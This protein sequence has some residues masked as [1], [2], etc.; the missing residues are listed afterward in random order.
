MGPNGGTQSASTTHLQPADSVGSGNLTTQSQPS[1]SLVSGRTTIPPKKAKTEDPR[2]AEAYRILKETYETKIRDKSQAFGN[3]VASKHRD[4]SKRTKAFVEHYINNILFDADLGK[5]DCEPSSGSTPVSSYSD[6]SQNTL[7]H[8][9]ITGQSPPNQITLL[10][11]ISSPGHQLH[12]PD[13]TSTEQ[14]KGSLVYYLNNF[15]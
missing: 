13:D 11:N 8:S 14:T 3:H 1:S 10:E 4:Y 5:F 15:E 6:S 12:V 9:V 2:A 7:M